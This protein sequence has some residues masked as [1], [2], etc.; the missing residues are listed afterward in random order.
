MVATLH[1]CIGGGNNKAS[2]EKDWLPTGVPQPGDFL[3]MAPGTT[4][5]VLGNDLAGSSITLGSS[6]TLNVTDANNSIC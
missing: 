4:M 2:N 3:Q 6:N 1:T 5:N